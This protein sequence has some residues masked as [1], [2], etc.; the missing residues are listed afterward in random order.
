MAEWVEATVQQMLALRSR[1]ILEIGAGLGLLLFRVAPTCEVYW[2]TD[3]CEGVVDFLTRHVRADRSLDHVKLIHAQASEIGNLPEGYFDQIVVSSVIQYFPSPHYLLD[4]L[5]KA[6]RALRP[7]GIIFLGDVRNL[8]LLE[9]FHRSVL[10]AQSPPTETI[11]T[12]RANLRRRVEGDT[13]LAVAPG[14]WHAIR[15][16]LPQITGVSIEPRRG[17][18]HN[19]FN[20][21]RYN[22]LLRVG[23]D[24]APEV[25]VQYEDWTSAGWS[26]DRLRAAIAD[27]PTTPLALSN[28]PNARSA[29]IAAA[30]Q[31]LNDADAV[32]TVAHFRRQLAAHPAAAAIDPQDLWDLESPSHEVHISWSHSDSAGSFD[33]AFIPRG[34]PRPADRINAASQSD[35]AWLRFCNDP[36]RKRRI[37]TLTSQLDQFLKT[38]LPNETVPSRLMVV[39]R[40]PTT[41]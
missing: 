40:L 20:C 19:E 36:V 35:G 22:V 18:A 17:R 28:I 24:P 2:A 38:Q 33:A 4:V 29:D 21:F 8:D 32:M 5:T 37:A 34:A 11:G 23:G 3:I 15:P 41:L 6:A 31:M 9:S 14:F 12:L 16:M 10:M 26:L 30:G 1:R 39:D 25:D 13:E 7:G 27:G